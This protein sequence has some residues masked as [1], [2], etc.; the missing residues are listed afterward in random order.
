MTGLIRD[1]SRYFSSLPP[2]VESPFSGVEPLSSVTRHHHGSQIHYHRKL[3]RQTLERHVAGTRPC[4]QLS[5]SEST[6]DA[7]RALGFVANKCAPLWGDWSF[8]QACAW[9]A[10]ATEQVV[11][12]QRWP[13]IRA[14]RTWEEPSRRWT[15][16][17]GQCTGTHTSTPDFPVRTLPQAKGRRALMSRVF[18]ECKHT[19][20]Q[21]RSSDPRTH[22]ACQPWQY[23]TRSYTNATTNFRP[24]LHKSI[25]S[26]NF[27]NT[28]TS[29]MFYHFDSCQ[30]LEKLRP[31]QRWHPSS[32]HHRSMPSTSASKHLNP[33]GCAAHSEIGS[34]FQ[35][36]YRK[37][38]I[39]PHFT[40]GN[41]PTQ[42]T[43]D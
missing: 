2:R 24:H 5:C 27:Y 10:K 30:S 28:Q 3:I 11:M 37:N 22:R 42:N 26:P 39:P 31:R 8:A 16:L 38:G 15:Q 35:P 25:N 34:L 32:S 12:T 4:D 18:F 14:S 7:R 33:D 19:G 13:G 40:H 21:A 23:A 9:A 1:R 29:C 43:Y 20:P 6:L 36:Q 17:R 41:Q